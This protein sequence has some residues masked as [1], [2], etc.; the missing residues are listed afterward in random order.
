MAEERVIAVDLGAS[1]GRVIGVQVRDGVVDI[2]SLHRFSNGPGLREIGGGSRWCWDF[3]GILE[4]VIE[5]ITMVASKGRVDS[6]AVDSWAVDYGLVDD[7]G[8]LVAPVTAYRDERH[9]PAFERLR[10]EIGDETIYGRTGIQFLPFNTLYQLAT[11]AGEPDRPLER[12]DRMLMIPDLI[13]N[14]LCGSVCGERTNAGS[15][16]CFDVDRDEW[17]EDL[18]ARAGIPAR[19]MPPVVAGESAEPLG[20]LLGSVARRVGLPPGT[21]V[22]ATAGHDTAAAVAA[23][24][25]RGAGDVFISSGTWSLVGFELESPVRTASAM[26]INATNEPGVFGTTRFLRNVSG[27]WLLQEC[28]RAWA[29][30]GRDHDWDTLA[31]M[32]AAAEPFRT[33]FDPDDPSLAAPGDMPERIARVVADA[34]EP[35]PVDDASMAR[36]ILDSVALKTARTIE[37]LGSVAGCD[38]ERIVVVGGGGANLLLD[39]LISS[40]TGLPLVTGSTEATAL[41]NA[42]VQIAAIRGLGN[43]D[44]LTDLL[45]AGIAA[46]GPDDLPE[47]RKA[48][49]AAL[50]RMSTGQP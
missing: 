32:A 23:A 10:R 48:A 19:I 14:R 17:A 27:L 28:R 41:G 30:A 7:R 12:A 37:E 24:P 20:G 34:G 43:R 47:V 21:P 38:P 22:R 31:A 39:R 8:G 29:G 5:G 50:A 25:L 9:R 33:V 49:P 46:A 35:S 3:E 2:D 42:A 15:T 6:I 13:A 40:C 1:S 4:G 16:Q 36:A 18:L 26:R 11:D 44:S 45:P